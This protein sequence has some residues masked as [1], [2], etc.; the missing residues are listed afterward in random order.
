MHYRLC[1]LPKI[2]DTGVEPV[3]SGIWV[4]HDIPFILP[5][6][7]FWDSNPRPTGYEP[8]TLTNWAKDPKNVLLQHVVSV[9]HYRC[10][11]PHNCYSKTTGLVG[12]EPTNYGVKVRGLTAWRQPIIMATQGGFEPPTCLCLL[13]SLLSYYAT[14]YSEYIRNR[15]TRTRTW[16]LSSCLDVV[17]NDE[18]AYSF[19]IHTLP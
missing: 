13:L 11:C 16:I 18:C 1:Y 14:M 10:W 17:L 3:I 4:Q 8:A 7:I 5:R 9:C 12:F 15:L 6:W 19:L 2:V